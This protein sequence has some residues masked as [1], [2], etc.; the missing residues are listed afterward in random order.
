MSY[1]KSGWQVLTEIIDLTVQ[2]SKKAHVN[3]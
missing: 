2:L 3:N 1:L